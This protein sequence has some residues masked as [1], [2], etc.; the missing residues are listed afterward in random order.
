MSTST[1]TLTAQAERLLDHLAEQQAEVEEIAESLAGEY[2]A[3]MRELLHDAEPRDLEMWEAARDSSDL[4]EMLSI[5]ATI[6]ELGEVPSDERAEIWQ[7]EMQLIIAASRWQAFVEIILPRILDASE[8]HADEQ[9]NDARPLSL[10]ELKVAARVGVSK[11]RIA[12]ART[13]REEARRGQS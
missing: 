5:D 8:R 6:D 13:R 7:A 3:R 9:V 1:E 2:A 11:D 4:A 10:D 12:T